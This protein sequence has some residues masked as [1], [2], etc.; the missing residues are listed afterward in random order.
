MYFE[1]YAI[2]ECRYHKE[3]EREREKGEEEEG[4]RPAILTLYSL[5]VKQQC[6]GGW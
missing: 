1:Q 6:F 3:K 4:E 2:F 5:F